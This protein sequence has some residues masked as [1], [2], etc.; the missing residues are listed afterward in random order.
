MMRTVLDHLVI[1]CSDLSQ[2]TDWLR[3][4]LGV[5]PEP[6]G[7][8]ASMG[9]HNR[10]LRLGPRSYLELLA[11]DPDAEP[12]PHPRWFGLDDREV[13][14]RSAREP[15]LLTWVAA[16]DDVQ[17][18]VARVPEL[19]D[20]RELSRDALRWRIALPED[21]GLLH[22]GIMPALI[23]WLGGAHPCNRLEDR[24]CELQSVVLE[25]P[26]ATEIA[27]ALQMIG[28]D[29][30]DAVEVGPKRLAAVIRGPSGEVTLS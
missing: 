2:G 12:P 21:G 8:H 17:E 16:T 4:R 5:E 9:T 3:V 26:S 18:A 24:G 19:G 22:D 30:W 1:A 29:G 28:F 10:L 7:R 23:Q 6:G 11:V 27:V 13:R 20:V 15:F 25:H 14:A